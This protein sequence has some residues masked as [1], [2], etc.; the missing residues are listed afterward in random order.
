MG[1]V[2]RIACTEGSGLKQGQTGLAHRIARIDDPYAS[3]CRRRQCSE[4]K[5]SCFTL[6]RPH[7]RP[8]SGQSLLRPIRQEQADP[9][10]A[11]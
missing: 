1:D 3:T 8:V 2:A 4:M 6:I 7:R 11:T 10:E 9:H 5:G